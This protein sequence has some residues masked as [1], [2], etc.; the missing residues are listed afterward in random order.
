[1]AYDIISLSKMEIQELYNIALWHKVDT[2]DKKKQAIIYAIL[3]AQERLLKSDKKR[4]YIIG[5]VTGLPRLEAL[6]KF[7]RAKDIIKRMGD[8]A[9]SP[10]DCVPAEAD[11]NTAMKICIPLLLGCDHIYCIDDVHSTVGGFIEKTIAGWLD[12]V[13]IKYFNGDMPVF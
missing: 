2:L 12:I 9:I 11:W 4:V 6:T 10:V 7:A 8:I 3:D 13:E 5:K 1:M